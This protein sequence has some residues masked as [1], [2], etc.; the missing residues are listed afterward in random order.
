MPTRDQTAETAARCLWREVFQR[1]GC[2]ERLLSDQGPAFEAALLQELCRAYGC[3]K[4]RTTP[5]RPQG[6]GACERWNQTLL[7]LLNTLTP[8]EQ[9]RWMEHIPDLV[10]AYN[11]TPHSS[12]GLAP[13]F[14][15]FGRHPRLPVDQ[16]W[17]VG[18]NG[19]IAEGVGWLQSH[20]CRLRRAIEEVQQQAGQRQEQ[21]QRRYYHRVR[22]LPLMPGERVLVRSFRRRARGKL[23]PYWDPCPQV[24]VGQPDPHWPVYHL[25]PEGQEGPVRTLH[26]RHLRI[27]PAGCDLRSPE[28]VGERGGGG[29]LEVG[30]GRE[31][32]ALGW[33]GRLSLGGDQG[34]QPEAALG[35][36]GSVSGEPGALLEPVEAGVGNPPELP[37]GLGASGQEEGQVTLR[38]SQRANLGQKP[39]RYCM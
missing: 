23:G 27:C 31:G 36:P 17:G 20:R 30:P 16:S 28:T 7:G 9:Q 15:L 21:D 34:G 11:S 22:A 26:R 39:A 32:H 37:E 13:F 5:Y 29:G 24:I 19:G 25:R 10:Q 33:P 35:Q 8:G 12:T 14:I 38:R 18:G 4:I 2:P 1:Y 3:K 6:N